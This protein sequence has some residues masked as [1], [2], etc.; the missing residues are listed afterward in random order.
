M[1]RNVS[2]SGGDN[3]QLLGGNRVIHHIN[4]KKYKKTNKTM[5]KFLSK[6]RRNLLK[7]LKRSF[8]YNT[9]KKR[10]T[11]KKNKTYKK[12]NLNKKRKTNNRRKM[13]GGAPLS[14][15]SYLE[16]GPRVDNNVIDSVQYS[17]GDN[18]NG[19]SALANPPPVVRTNGCLI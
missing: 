13:R 7:T 15:A 2:I 5:R 12:R 18:L 3:C 16:E 9:K 4:R 10:K 19:E 1:P 11:N 17:V 6:K 14:P 8:K